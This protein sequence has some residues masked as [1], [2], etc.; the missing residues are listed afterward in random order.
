[1][2][3][4]VYQELLTVM[5]SRRGPYAGADIPEF[6]TL[7]ETLFTPEEAEV[8][9]A[10]TTRPATAKKIADRMNRDE[11]RITDVLEMMANKGLCATFKIDGVRLYQGVPFMPGIFEYQFMPGRETERDK[12]IAKL[13]HAYKKAYA[14]AKGVTQ[15]DFP[16]TRVIPVDRTINV[17]NTIHTYD[18]VATYIEKYD[19]IGVGTCYCRHAAKLRGEDVHGMPMDVC[20]WF[21]KAAEYAI[22]RLGGR[23]VTKPE[24]LAILDQT[25]EAGLVHMSRNTTKD[26]DFLCN[27]DRWHCEVI[28]TVL[29]QPKPGLIF[30]SGY[31]PNFD[32]DLCVACEAC[33]ERCPSEALTLGDSNVPTVNLDRCFGCAA[34]A[35]GCPEGAIAMN[36]KPDYPIPPKDVKSLAAALK[37]SRAS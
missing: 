34:C 36:A 31:A 16:V 22:E 29:K 30:N 2:S 5:Q 12:K 27:C 4:Q 28:T 14:A 23:Q 26:I 33:M 6:Y 15:A 19:S 10:L 35:T 20:M 1:M 21:G 13:I 18:Q 25:E 37:A 9:N 7:V 8:N 17:S 11:N 3:H 24:A 32:Q